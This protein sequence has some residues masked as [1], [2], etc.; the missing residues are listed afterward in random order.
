MKKIVMAFALAATMAVA[1][2]GAGGPEIATVSAVSLG[3]FDVS[4][5]GW[6]AAMN[7]GK[8]APGSPTAVRIARDGRVALSGFELGHVARQAAAPDPALDAL[9]AKVTAHAEATF[10]RLEGGGGQ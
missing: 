4:L 3:G 8:L 1:A 7:A 6:D 9:Y 5:Y 2:C 10:A